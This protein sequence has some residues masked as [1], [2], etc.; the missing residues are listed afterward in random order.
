MGPGDGPP[1]TAGRAGGPDG[2]RDL[3]GALAALA[4]SDHGLDLTSARLVPSDDDEL[5]LRTP[6]GWLVRFAGA[7][8]DPARELALL[9][10][11]RGA[12]LADLPTDAWVGTGP[13]VIAYRDVQGATFDAAEYAAADGRRRNRLA[14]SIARFLVV[15]HTALSPEEATALGVPTVDPDGLA[16]SVVPRLQEVPA[17]LRARATD[18]VEHFREAWLAEPRP[19]RQ[20]LLHGGLHAGSMVL[21]DPVGELTGVRQLSHVRVGPPSLDLRYLARVPE[22]ASPGVRRDLMQRVADQYARTGIT[23]DV[24]GARAAMAMSD[25]AAA[26]RS[27]DFHRFE[28]DDGVWAWPGAD[29]G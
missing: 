11:L 17:H 8:A 5:C 26:I 28:P 24:D 19:G 15:L 7:E 29:R 22:E 18:V 9:A 3:P 2:P 13:R 23:L 1:V 25:L 16:E 4:D 10:R 14:A 27:G 21:R 6:D 20:V 12:L